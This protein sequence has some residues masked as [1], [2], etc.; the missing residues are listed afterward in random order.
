ML[1]IVLMP[2]VMLLFACSRYDAAADGG[3]HHYFTMG[4]AALHTQHSLLELLPNDF[5][6]MG[7]DI[8]VGPV[9]LVGDGI[10]HVGAADYRSVNNHIRPVRLVDTHNMYSPLLIEIENVPDDSLTV[11]IRFSYTH[12]SDTL[13]EVVSGTLNIPLVRDSFSLHHRLRLKGQ[14]L[15]EGTPDKGTSQKVMLDLDYLL[16]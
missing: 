1:R 9:E 16:M 14:P 7:G 4:E 11:L 5:G 12:S 3:G 8:V 10:M 6:Q 13:L 15:Y 2:I